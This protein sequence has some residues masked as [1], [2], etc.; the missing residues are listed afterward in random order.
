MTIATLTDARSPTDPAPVVY[1]ASSLITES[2][3]Y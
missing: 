2:E 1:A 3:R